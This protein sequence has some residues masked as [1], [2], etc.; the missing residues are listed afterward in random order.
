MYLANP[1]AISCPASAADTGT[2]AGSLVIAPLAV[3]VAGGVALPHAAKST[4]LTE[5]ASPRQTDTLDGVA[6]GRRTDT[7]ALIT[8]ASLFEISDRSDI[9]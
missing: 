8:R 5:K 2:D 1:D 4:R 9:D 7:A 3:K 6:S